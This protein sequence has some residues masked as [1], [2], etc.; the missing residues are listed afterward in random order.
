MNIKITRDTGKGRAFSFVLEEGSIYEDI[1]LP[2]FDEFNLKSRVIVFLVPKITPLNWSQ[3][4]NELI[5]KFTELNVRQTSIVG[6]G[7][8]GAIA[9]NIALKENK[10]IRSLILI[11]SNTRSHPSFSTKLIDKIE[12]L[13][14]LGLPLRTN[15]LDFD[16]K[17]FLQ[18]LRCPALVITSSHSNNY[19]KDQAKIIASRIPT[20]W[21]IPI[22]NNLISNLSK[23]IE[24]F[25]LVPA[26]CPQK[27]NR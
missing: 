2:L 8:S 17:P 9:Q 24:E 22:K 23:K 20:A 13:L 11:D 15:R 4:S 6:S 16:S 26:K 19:T 1:L 3:I 10:L 14:P 21:H 7:S 12:K 18:R 27:A 25:E 5:N